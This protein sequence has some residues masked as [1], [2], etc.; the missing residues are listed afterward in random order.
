[1]ITILYQ[2]NQLG[3][4]GTEK[5]IFTFV[6]NIDR[7]KFNI[8]L[9]FVTDI[10][11][12]KYYR[13]KLLAVFSRKY[14]KIFEKRYVTDFSRKK[15]FENLLGKENVILGTKQDFLRACAR[16]KPDIIHFNRGIENEF[17][18]TQVTRLP[19]NSKICETNIFGA[20]ANKEYL[21]RLSSIL[22]ISKWLQSKSKWS[23]SYNCNILYNP[24]VK[25][26]STDNLRTQLN[27]PKTAIIIGRISRPGMDDGEFF[28]NIINMFSSKDVYFLTIGASAE[29]Q[30]QQANN[31][32]AIFTPTTTSEITLSMFYNTIDI[33]FHYR[34]EGETF[35]MNIAE[36][37]IH[38]KPVISHK[39]AT[40]NAQLELLLDNEQHCGIIV[41]DTSDIKEFGDKL[42]MLVNDKNLRIELGR[43]GQK[44]A[45]RL[46]EESVVTRHLETLYE[47][48]MKHEGKNNV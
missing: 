19:V 2:L 44:K 43:N 35:G 38:G 3:Y 48:F 33:L 40:D 25:P 20:P 45:M 18:T 8:K 47:S 46:Y 14:K 30:E 27:L 5:A 28:N 26:A 15:D 23:E 17:Y 32:K 1:M 6:N 12:R 10:Y 41:N 42:E 29:L 11:T 37:M 13:R 39:S 22:F 36:A 9:F 21:E 16:F 31:K 34:K 4:G 24:I 7:Q